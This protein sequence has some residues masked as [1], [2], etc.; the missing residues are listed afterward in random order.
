[1]LILGAA[2][3]LGLILSRA[4]VSESV[5]GL[6]T[7]M[8]DNPLLFLLLINVLFILLGMVI[9]ATAVILVTV[10][11]LLPVAIQ[12][13]IDPIHFGVIMIM[14]LMLGLLTPPVGSVLYVTSSVTGR[15][16]DVVFKGIMP[17]LIPLVLAL[18]AVTLFP[19]LVLFLPRALGF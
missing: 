16:V 12:F 18:V 13:G 7:G 6:L 15:P 11:V 17:F 4:R 2:A 19:D 8:T 10:P 9:D 14:N 5:A 3:V 1:M